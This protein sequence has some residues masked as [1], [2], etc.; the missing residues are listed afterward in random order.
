MY[1]KGL[2]FHNFLWLWGENRPRT[3]SLWD[4]PSSAIDCTVMNIMFLLFSLSVVVV[5]LS[6]VSAETHLSVCG[7]SGWSGPGLSWRFCLVWSHGHS[8]KEGVAREVPQNHRRSWEGP[9]Y[10]SSYRGVKLLLNSLFS[11]YVCIFAVTNFE[12]L[13][14]SV[15]FF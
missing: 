6:R 9:A 10:T 8:E 1:Q 2:F 5:G 3:F 13:C 7:G 15:R 14:F 12:I 11:V 4:L